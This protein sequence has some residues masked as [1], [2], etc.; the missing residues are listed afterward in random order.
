VIPRI[1]TATYRLQFNSAFRFSDARRI[2]SY[3]CDLGISDMYSSP[4][5]KA[6]P[7]S[8]HGY[9]I[10]DPNQLNPEIG[11]E[12]EYDELVAEMKH[13]GMGQ[14]L[15]IVPNH[16]CVT[17]EDN[18]WW[19]D[20]L[21]NG[22][23]SPYAMFF[24]VE[25]NPTKRELKNKVLLPVLGD[26][27][28]KALENGELRL[29]F[30]DGAFFL[31]YF[32]HK[33]PILPETYTQIFGQS[34]ADLTACLG[35]DNRYCA[36]LVTIMA[37]LEHLPPHSETS[38]EKVAERYRL[39][40]VLK[41]RLKDLYSESVEI[42]KFIDE[43]LQVINGVKGEPRSFDLLDNLLSQQVY[44]PAL[45]RV[46]T[47]EINYRRFFDINS[48]G[49]LRMENPDVFR[50]THK[51]I[52]TLIRQ[53]KVTGLRVDHPDGLYNPS[54]YFKELQKQCFIELQKASVASVTMEVP[55][56]YDS[57]DL[58][59]EILD[60]Y[61]GAVS[62]DPDYKPFYIVG[63]KILT[64][65]ERMP[66]EWP[67]FS[68]TGYVFL[69]SVSG[70]FVN[71]A[72]AKAF[73]T[74]Y[75]QFTRSKSSFQDIAYEKRKL[76][77]QVAMSGEINTLGHFLDGLSEKNRHTR[78]FTLNSL[79]DAIIEV[80]ACFPVYRT[81]INSYDVKERDR[82][83]IEAAIS[84]ATRKNPATSS[85]IFRFLYDVLTLS[86]PEGIDEDDKKRWL[87][88]VMRFQQ[89]TSPIMAKGVEDTAFY[90]YNRLVS[91]NEV[92]GNPEKFGTTLE[93]FHG[94]NIER[95][96]FWPHALIATSTHDT[97]T[98]E[99]VKARLNVL[100]EIAGRWKERLIKWQRFNRRKK[101]SVDGQRVPDRNE[102][103]LLYQVLIGA[104]P[105]AEQADEGNSPDFRERIKNHM[106]KAAREAKINTSWINPNSAYE[107]A[108]TIF[109]D[110]ILAER[111]DNLFLPDF[112]AFQYMVAEYGMFN[113]LSQCLLK[114]TAPGVPDFYQGTELWNFCLVDPDNRRPVNYDIRI[115]MLNAL[116]KR[117]EELS[118]SVLARDLTLNRRDGSI[119]LYLIYKALNFRKAH[120][121]VFDGGEYMPLETG[122]QRSNNICASARRLDGKVIITC[123]PRLLTTVTEHPHDLPLGTGVWGDAVLFVPFS[124]EGT[125][126]RNVFTGEV[127][128][129]TSKGGEHTLNVAALLA[130]FPVALLETIA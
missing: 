25:W 113:A 126:Y 34:M 82:Q 37:A 83:Y 127:T 15:D 88:F 84:R 119:K 40:E 109:V 114:I 117:E 76:V 121:G 22:Q 3:L 7:G 115:K 32:D 28:G 89:L 10:A 108:L 95:S 54:E 6:K 43:N 50:E 123:V 66:E 62:A 75:A 17:C 103:Y 13:Y 87:D 38:E 61:D 19:M 81:Y 68:T 31:H 2:L 33:F 60:R 18:G 99:D 58:E 26:Q 67:I 70:I 42:R 80:I 1:P 92:G 85:A 102:E 65:S 73:D 72:S 93:T 4:Y 20:L 8:P 106:L 49:A 94:Q 77:M 24:D 27:Y 98:S 107:D 96:K 55:L 78:D 116:K 128:T 53:A 86:F 129:V 64:K 46:A 21:E 9:D 101:I 110:A 105:M 57:A 124:E 130:D 36:E 104:W 111:P 51:L 48:L 112:R 29:A 90:V 52:F 45:W 5:F 35:L 91:L 100:S 74:L 12:E 79:T 97:K 30:Q 11:T 118:P 23:S 71:T 69:N 120:R 56:N 16:M 122:G 59:S 39:K 63:E 125:Q 14:I 41:V 44:R 47:D